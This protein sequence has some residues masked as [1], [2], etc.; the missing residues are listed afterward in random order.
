MDQKGIAPLV[1]VAVV[2]VAVAVVS[3]GAYVAMSGGSGTNT[4]T[5]SV[6]IADATSL[7]F[8]LDATL[9]GVSTTGTFMAKGLGS[10]NV[11][12]RIEMTAAGQDMIIIIDGAERKAWAYGDGQW[13][14]MTSTFDQYWEQWDQAFEGYKSQLGGWTGGDFTTTEPSTGMVMRIYDVEV[15]PNLPD[16]LFQPT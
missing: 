3:V 10:S 12:M 7:S 8:K 1:I 11:K 2:V 15:N 13:M 14:D 9:Q 16:S 5:T 4:T 6:N